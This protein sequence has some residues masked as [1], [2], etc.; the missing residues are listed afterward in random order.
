MENKPIVIWLDDMRNPSDFLGEKFLSENS[1]IW[2]KC[3]KDFAFY[4]THVDGIDSIYFDHDLGLGKKDGMDC[5]KF[6]INH[7]I[8]TDS[9]LPK[10]FS[11]SSNPPGRENILGIL[12]SYKKFRE[13]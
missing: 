8:I 12:D 9:P 3:F 4:V 1:V 10:Y 2:C 13:K 7:C 5:A 11:Q 6:L